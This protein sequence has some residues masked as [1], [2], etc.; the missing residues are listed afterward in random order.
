MW[1]ELIRKFVFVILAIC[2]YPFIIRT[3]TETFFILFGGLYESHYIITNYGI[4][5]SPSKSINVI[6]NYSNLNCP[7]VTSTIFC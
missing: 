4:A 6:R 2:Y 1:Q 3:L 7:L 5:G